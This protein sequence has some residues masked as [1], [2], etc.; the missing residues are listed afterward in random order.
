MSRSQTLDF[1]QIR[2]PLSQMTEER[3]RR[4]IAA[5]QAELGMTL[6]QVGLEEYLRDEF[7]LL[8]V[9]SGGSEG[10]FL[11]V[12]E[13]LKRRHCYILTSGESNS[14]AA[15]MEI[16]SYLRRRGG[17]GQIRF[18]RAE[19]NSCLYRLF[20]DLA[21]HRRDHLIFRVIDP[22]PVVEKDQERG[23]PGRAPQEVPAEG[24]QLFRSFPVLFPGIPDVPARAV[25]DLRQ[26]A[27]VLPDGKGQDH[28]VFQ[29]NLVRQ[30]PSRE[31]VAFPH[32]FRPL[33][34]GLSRRLRRRI[35]KGHARR[36]G[37]GFR[38]RRRERLRRTE[39]TA[40]HCAGVA[41]EAENFNP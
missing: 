36:I 16:L 39:A 7:A 26:D 10:Y 32:R 37:D 11:E 29:D 14:L 33:R 5:L 12:F 8:Y 6:R 40:V 19:C 4:Y 18:D 15:S 25:F 9:A 35:S 34:F 23:L 28:A 2:S 21:D 30:D 13:Q 17:S 31:R 38:S 1:Y 27:P 3:M 41:L 22:V 24:T 20:P